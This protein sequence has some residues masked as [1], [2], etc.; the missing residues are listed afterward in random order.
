MPE[1]L[2]QPIGSTPEHRVGVSSTPEPG[3]MLRA[4]DLTRRMSPRGTVRVMK[5][6]AYGRLDENSYPSTHMVGPGAPST[7]WCVNLADDAGSFWLLCFDFDGK[8]SHGV[9]PELMELAHDECD[10]LSGVLG[11]LSIAHVVCQS[12][13]TGGRHIW[14]ALNTGVPTAAVATLA[15]AAR[16]NYRT[17]DHGMLHNARTGAARPP[18]SPHR[19]GSSSSVL[20]G[21]LDSLIAPSTDADMIADLARALDARKP[22]V[23]A[24][25]TAPSGPVDGRHHA[26]RPLSAAGTA[27][28]ATIGGGSNPSWTGFMCL[29]AAAHAGWQLADVQHAAKTAPGMEHYR[30]KNTGRGTRRTRTQTEAADRLGRQWDKAQHIAA[31]QRPLPPAGSEPKD[32]SELYGIVDAVDAV[33]SS[34]H[35][36]PGRWGSTETAQ[37]QRS[38]LAALAYLSLQTGKR[39]VAASIRDLALMTGLG[40]T[41]AADALTALSEQDLISRVSTSDG[42]NAAEWRMT[43]EFS[44]TSGTL[45]SQ[46]LHNPRPP[47]E[48]FNTRV[49][50]VATLE[51][52]LT[53]QRHDLFTRAGLGHLAGKIY[54]VLR[55]IPALTVESAARLLGVSTKHTITVLSRLRR[56]K[57]I[58]RHPEGW[59]RSKRDLRDHAA[60]VIGVAGLLLDRANRYAKEREVWA[61]WLAEVNQ[62]NSTPRRRTRRPHVSS[63]TLQFIDDL[64]GERQWPRY[65][66]AA[67]G[68]ADHKEARYWALNGMLE[69]GS[70]WHSSAA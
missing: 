29:L 12:S 11:E 33:L 8:D 70:L 44:T 39:I 52:L 3:D 32:L 38:V 26:H 37:S 19:D 59:A 10:A 13:G 1:T 27:H 35:T 63:R 36:A 41:T 18:L 22:E 64:P 14:V 5:R 30:S 62:M 66:R 6:D 58:I 28:M 7:P 16:A 15:L 60:K 61:W 2:P 67:D 56:H 9:S 17:L 50:Q 55:Q 40:R 43:P 34:F 25:E 24:L 69:P 48:L 53:D 46:P 21:R 54:A 68:R 57:L 31:L 20:R 51:N 47:A 65:P 49:D 45:R 42:G 23:R 4:W